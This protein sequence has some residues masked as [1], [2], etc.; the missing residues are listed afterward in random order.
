MG[1]RK[2]YRS[3]KNQKLQY[4]EGYIEDF[5]SEKL[6]REELIENKQ[7]FNVLVDTLNIGIAIHTDGV[8]KFA[9]K[10]ACKILGYSKSEDKSQ[11][12]I[13][14]F[15]HPD[16]KSIVQNRIEKILKGEKLD[17][18]Y[19]CYFKKDKSPIWVET[20]GKL[21]NYQS[22]PSVQVSFKDANEKFLTQQK[23]LKGELRF[24]G[25]F[26]NV[27]HGM[28]VADEKGFIISANKKFCKILGYS[29]RNI[30]GKS[31]GEFTYYEEKDV[32]INQFEQLISESLNHYKIK[33]GTFEKMET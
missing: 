22:K 20:S 15:I 14:N 7:K 31:F 5:S 28:V 17:S 33:K 18:I 29:E 10:N 1:K 9:N 8:L 6:I 12:S 23:L 32:N 2:R 25:M 16:F 19:Q 30:L 3:F 24:R 26:E 21:I 13:E 4:L 27:H 11:L